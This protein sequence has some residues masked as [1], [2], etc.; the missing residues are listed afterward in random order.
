MTIK[1]S[2]QAAKSPLST[3]EDGIMV[4]NDFAAV[5][6]GSTSKGTLSL[7]GKKSGRVAMETVC[8]SIRLMDANI[9]AE[10]AASKLTESIYKLYL[11]NHLLDDAI[12]H[13]EN[14]FTCSA[15]IF[16]KKRSEVWFIGD[17]QCRINGITYTNGKL[18]DR[19]LT[20]IRCDAIN[21]L[22]Q[23]GHS[24]ED[25]QHNDIGRAFI[26]DALKDQ[27]HFQND[28]NDNPYRYAVIDGFPIDENL[29][30]IIP[31]P[32]H[33]NEIVLASDGY[34]VL[35]DTLDSS[36]KELQRLLKIDKLC[37]HE[38]KSTKGMMVGANSYDDRTYFRIEI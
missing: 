18:V 23:N 22:L 27:C 26:M 28:K 13:A 1:E 38:N 31:V 9:T 5:V 14:R 33:I 19:I 30:K 4:T 36:E 15:V 12:T 17:C 20:E 10:E 34:P 24:I 21:Y 37:Y 8:K 32:P 35:C 25:L 2:F 6:D 11:D 29:I 7:Y 16:S 3:I